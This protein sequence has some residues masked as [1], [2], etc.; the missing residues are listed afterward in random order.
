MCD[1]GFTDKVP[2]PIKHQKTVL[3]LSLI[4]HITSGLQTSLKYMTA[5]S[6]IQLKTSKCGLDSTQLDLSSHC[7]DCSSYHTSTS[8]QPLSAALVLRRQPLALEVL[9]SRVENSFCQ[10][11]KHLKPF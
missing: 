5:I 9:S 4:T 8:I 10:A 11:A 2:Q 7:A 1:P 6:K 3:F